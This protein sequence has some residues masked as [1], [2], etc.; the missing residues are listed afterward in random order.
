MGA[1]GR[2]ETGLQLKDYEIL[3]DTSD[4]HWGFALQPK[5]A[6]GVRGWHLRARSESDRLEWTQKLLL[7]SMLPAAECQAEMKASDALSFL[8]AWILK[9]PLEPV[10]FSSL[11]QRNLHIR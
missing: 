3:V 2:L 7:A 5:S 6:S 11:K 1:R 8:A 10:H 4:P 9:I